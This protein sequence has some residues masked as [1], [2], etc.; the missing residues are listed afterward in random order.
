MRTLE[1]SW[2]CGNA[3]PNTAKDGS[4]RKGE[5]KRNL[6]KWTKKPERGKW[7]QNPCG[8]RG[9]GD[10][11]ERWI[12]HDRWK[13]RQ[14]NWNLFREALDKRSKLQR[15]ENRNISELIA[16]VCP[17]IGIPMNC[18]MTKGFSTNLGCRQWI[19]RWRR[20]NL[21]CIW[22]SMERWLRYDS[23]CL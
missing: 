11:W 18:S 10:T 13:E 14:H 20:W 23:E 16:P 19:C 6:K 7:D 12:C 22:S 15:N 5:T 3:C 8:K 9:W 21:Q 2:S 1:D 17:I 4:K